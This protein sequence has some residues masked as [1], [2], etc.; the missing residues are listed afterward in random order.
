MSS[1]ANGGTDDAPTYYVKVPASV[2]P[3]KGRVLQ[4]KSVRPATVSGAAAASEENG[5]STGGQEHPNTTPDVHV[6]APIG[7]RAWQSIVS[8]RPATIDNVSD[9][10]CVSPLWTAAESGNASSIAESFDAPSTQV[11]PAALL[12]LLQLASKKGHKD[13]VIEILR[14]FPDIVNQLFEGSSALH[15]AAREGHTRVIRALLEFNADVNVLDSNGKTPVALAKTRGISRLL[16]ANDLEHAAKS[17]E[18]PKRLIDYCVIIRQTTT[19]VDENDSPKAG[20]PK[21]TNGVAGSGSGP[22]VSSEIL[23]RW[24]ETDHT[25]LALGDIH[26]LQLTVFMTCNM[27]DEDEDEDEDDWSSDE[28]GS[29]NGSGSGEGGAGGGGSGGGAADAAGPRTHTAQSATA[30]PRQS[31]RNKLDIEGG[32][33]A[34]QEERRSFRT[35]RRRSAR[36]S[37]LTNDARRIYWCGLRLDEPSKLSEKT[38][39]LDADDGEATSPRSHKHTVTADYVLLISHWPFLTLFKLFVES[40]RTSWINTLLSTSK[41]RSETDSQLIAAAQ[42]R[43][44]GLVACQLPRPNTE[45]QVKWPGVFRYRIFRPQGL[46]VVDPYCFECLFSC[47]S[48]NNIATLIGCLLVEDNILFYTRRLHLLAPALEA[49]QSLIFPFRWTQVYVPILPAAMI[50]MTDSPVPWLMGTHVLNV[51]RINFKHNPGELPTQITMVNLD[52]N[53]V[54][55]PLMSDRSYTERTSLPRQ[56]KKQFCRQLLAAVSLGKFS[57]QQRA[58]TDRDRRLLKAASVGDFSIA[59]GSAK[60]ADQ[61]AVLDSD[62]RAAERLREYYLFWNP[63]KLE[64]PTFLRAVLKS[65]YANREEK[66]YEDLAT[67]YGAEPARP[68]DD[69]SDED[70]S[71]AGS[72]QITPLKRDLVR[73]PVALLAIW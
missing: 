33:A 53:S 52:E 50:D 56:V 28:D 66:L 63:Q 57:E 12:C 73:D 31:R 65:K 70:A 44:Q 34:T 16:A 2:W 24:P 62:L 18:M 20:S 6:L 48:I 32:S 39:Q 49:L 45:V 21:Q 36:I 19:W 23:C 29:G 46:P 69:D 7:L 41:G 27:E 54:A 71:E 14:R 15:I 47:L 35:R 68:S 58:A 26:P 60:K 25:D 13:V 59:G 37:A 9:T 17:H 22:R 67:I 61:D 64:D 8:P 4:I 11:T 51:G 38:Q 3:L 5:A 30:S 1:A 72:N 43:L 40:L 10:L 55:P 42:A